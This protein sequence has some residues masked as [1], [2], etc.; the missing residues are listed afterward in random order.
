MA[1][2][3]LPEIFHQGALIKRARV[4]TTANKSFIVDP[5]PETL[6]VNST[7]YVLL[8]HRTFTDEENQIHISALETDERGV[9]ISTHRGPSSTLMPIIS[10]VEILP[11]YD[12][13]GALE[14]WTLT[15]DAQPGDPLIPSQDLLYFW[16]LRPLIQ[17]YTSESF[18]TGQ[19][20]Y[21]GA[22]Q[23]PEELWLLVSDQRG[24][25]RWVAVPWEE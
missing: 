2:A 25:E 20:I 22:D 11:A 9:M 19:Q 6:S 17:Q 1:D 16:K 3:N 23:R 12:S 13:E 10:G 21:L 4:L 24:G 18:R 5:T 15:A 7:D 14:G 8:P